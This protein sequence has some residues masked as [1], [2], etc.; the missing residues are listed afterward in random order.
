M[1]EFA[2]L[3]YCATVHCTVPYLLLLILE[4][5]LEFRLLPPELEQGLLDIREGVGY[6]PVAYSELYILL[7]EC[8]HLQLQVIHLRPAPE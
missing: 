3:Y 2:R 1:R 5:G 8:R 7:R 6:T 4:G